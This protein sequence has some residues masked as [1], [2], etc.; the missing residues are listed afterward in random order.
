MIPRR[1][2]TA[3]PVRLNGIHHRKGERRVGPFRLR[4]D[5]RKIVEVTLEID[6]DICRAIPVDSQAV[7]A[8]ENLLGTKFI[9]I[10]KGK[11]QGYVKPAAECPSQRQTAELDDLFQQGNYHAGGAAESSRKVDGI[12]D[13]CRVRPGHHRQAPDGRYLVQQ[14]P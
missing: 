4:H 11:V 7:I 3:A 10:K 14:S 6:N 2:R 12:V 1:W 5:P 8:A 13:Q 9:N